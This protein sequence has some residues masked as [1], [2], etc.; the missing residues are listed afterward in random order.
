VK[1]LPHKRETSRTDKFLIGKSQGSSKYRRKKVFKWVL[2]KYGVKSVIFYFRTYVTGRDLLDKS[3]IYKDSWFL[4]PNNEQN[5]HNLVIQSRYAKTLTYATVEVSA[6]ATMQ[7]RKQI[8]A[9]FLPTE[10]STFSG[11]AIREFT[12]N[13]NTKTKTTY[14]CLKIQRTHY[15]CTPRT[16]WCGLYTGIVWKLHSTDCATVWRLLNYRVQQ[17]R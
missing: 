9:M 13:H 17:S 14:L 16:L 3:S 10:I 11:K 15:F 7:L 8:G 2:D 6:S 1:Q 4:N 5:W 12:S